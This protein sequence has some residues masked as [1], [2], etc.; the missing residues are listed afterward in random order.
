MIP[1]YIEE[2]IQK[3]NNLILKAITLENEIENWY[4]KRIRQYSPCI[5]QV[6]DEEVCDIKGDEIATF[7]SIENIKYNLILFQ[8]IRKGA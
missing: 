3:H 5:D 1:K 7:I 2:K 6:S 8:K 4:E